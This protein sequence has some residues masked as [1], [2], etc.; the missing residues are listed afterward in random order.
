MGRLSSKPVGA[1]RERQF[2]TQSTEMRT[3]A[4]RWRL[5]GYITDIG[6]CSAVQ[7]VNTCL[8]CRKQRR[9]AFRIT[10]RSEIFQQQSPQSFIF[11]SFWRSEW[12]NLV[13][14]HEACRGL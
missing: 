8:S 13:P 7:S 4:D 6:D 3:F 12:E 11:V 9:S 14:P 5:C 2:T 10:D 1:G